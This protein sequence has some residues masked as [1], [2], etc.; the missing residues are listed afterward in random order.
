M[1]TL[2]LKYKAWVQ[3]VL[4]P[5]GPW[6]VFIIAAVDSALMGVPLDP[7]IAYFVYQD[8]RRFWLYCVMASAGSALGSVVLW[9]IGLKGEEL[10]LEKRISKQRLEDIRR[11]FQKREFWALMLPSM[12]P[13]PAPFKLFVLSAGVFKMKLSHFLLAIFAGRMLRFI[14]LSVLV[15]AFGPQIVSMAAVLVKEHLPITLGT[16]AAAIVVGYVIYRLWRE[17]VVELEH[18][19]ESKLHERPTS[20]AEG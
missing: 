18:E 6:G 12:L 19:I 4:I 20:R 1:K 14:I 2:F 7:L 3:A 9:Y 5:L 17:P 8:P 11:R 13:P 15:I 16:I 10:V